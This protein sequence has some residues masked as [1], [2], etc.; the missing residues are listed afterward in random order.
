VLVLVGLLLGLHLVA[1]RRRVL[2][3]AVFVAS[4]VIVWLGVELAHG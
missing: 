1:P 2:S 3:V 4:L